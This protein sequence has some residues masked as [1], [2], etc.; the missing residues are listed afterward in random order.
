MA[1][2]VVNPDSAEEWDI[3]LQ[4]GTISLGR[5]E[6]NDFQIEHSSVSS[7]HCQIEVTG[8]GV[9]IKDLGSTNG[10]F[11]NGRMIQGWA[12]KTESKAVNIPKKVDLKLAEGCTFA[13]EPEEACD[14]VTQVLKQA[15]VPKGAPIVINIDK[16]KH[17]G[18]MDIVANRSELV[19]DSDEMD[20]LG[21]AFMHTYIYKVNPNRPAKEK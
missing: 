4:P 5:G 9:R 2:L 16:S 19:I 6:E 1:R 17:I 12:R 21:M 13:I 20:E 18:S 14:E 8:S 11:I 15:G 7:S 3:E 10:T